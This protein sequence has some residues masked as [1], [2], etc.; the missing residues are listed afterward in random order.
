[1]QGFW[2]PNGEVLD[3]MESSLLVGTSLAYPGDVSLI[4]TDTEGV[5]T[6]VTGWMW[7]T[8]GDGIPDTAAGETLTQ[9]M[10]DTAYNMG[11]VLLLYPVTDD[12]SLSYGIYDYDTGALFG[13]DT[14]PYLD[15]ST[16]DAQFR[17]AL[18]VAGGDYRVV[19]YSDITTN[20]NFTVKKGNSAEDMTTLRLDLNGFKLKRERFNTT[21]GFLYIEDYVRIYVYS[22]R[23]GGEIYNSN[24]GTFAG[25]EYA[26]GS[27]FI[28][29]NRNTNK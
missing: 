19:L 26:M 27:G 25:K 23:E 28:Y 16:F 24:Y 1:M 22:S 13:S 15:S 10:W 4:P 2:D 14:A 9:Q 20:N 21:N 8:D 11:G 7:D 3:P 12:I 6:T 29:Q 5:Y 18:S 17:A